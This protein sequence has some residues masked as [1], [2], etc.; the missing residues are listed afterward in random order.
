[1]MI[2]H[3]GSPLE[4]IIDEAQRFARSDATVLVTGE[5]GTGKEVFARLIHDASPRSTHAFVAVN[6]GAIPESLIEAELFGHVKGAFTGAHAARK[7]RVAMA[8]GGTLFLD[9]I[10]ELSLP[11]QVKLLRLLQ[12]RTYEPVGSSETQKA[13][14]RLVAATNRDLATEVAAGRF[15]SDLYYRIFV[16]PL[17]IPPLRD[18]GIDDLMALFFS[19]WKKLG[20]SRVVDNGVFTC[21][22]AYPWPGNVRELENFV[23]RLSVCARG[24]IIQTSDVPE[25]YRHTLPL[26]TRA[27]P[28]PEPDL[29]ELSWLDALPGSVETT[30]PVHIV[31]ALSPAHIVAAPQPLAPQ[32]L[33]PQPL[34][35]QPPAP[36]PTMAITTMSGGA[37][38]VDSAV[39]LPIDLSV[40]LDAIERGYIE[41]ALRATSGNK[42]A[43]ADLLGLQ[44]TTLVAKCKKHGLG[45]TGKN[46]ESASGPAGLHVEFA[47]EQRP[48]LMLRGASFKVAVIREEVIELIPAAGAMVSLSD[49][50]PVAGSCVVDGETLRLF[51]ALHGRDDGMVLIA[52]AIPL[53]RS[54]LVSLQRSLVKRRLRIARTG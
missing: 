54:Q 50:S 16:C 39:R 27:E 6:C 35:P 41:A 20:N 52:L 11:M 24:D 7:G 1:M 34:A 5:T 2:F 33:A 46:V 44:R 26:R 23:E 45:D 30:P 14:F 49:T 47:E 8:Q 40:H 12:Q 51:G 3:P 48:V 42:Q 21:M 15:R 25:S 31:A 4:A 36:Q 10:G 13:D 38:V 19:F 53:E 43:S 22:S 28:E 18:R 9:E 29:N 17:H 37:A 32:P